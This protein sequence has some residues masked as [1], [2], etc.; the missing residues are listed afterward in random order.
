[1]AS[2]S[3]VYVQLGPRHW[4]LGGDYLKE[5]EPCNQCLEAEDVGLALRNELNEKGYIYLKHVLPEESVLKAKIAGRVF[6]WIIKQYTMK[7]LY[8]SSR[9]YSASS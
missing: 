3:K 8:F 6:F 7:Y 1:M 2:E 4:E 5:L 9:T